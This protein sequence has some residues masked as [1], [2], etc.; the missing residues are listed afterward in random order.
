MTCQ[1]MAEKTIHEGR[2]IKRIRELPGIKQEALAVESGGDWNQEKISLPEG[3]E[4]ME[5]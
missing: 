3:K 1:A 5:P 4:A 2:N